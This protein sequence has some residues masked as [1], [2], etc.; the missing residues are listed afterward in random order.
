M[1]YDPS[2]IKGFPRT[3]RCIISPTIIDQHAYV[4]LKTEKRTIFDGKRFDDFPI[5]APDVDPPHLHPR[6]AYTGLLI[7]KE[8]DKALVGHATKAAPYGR[9]VCNLYIALLV[10]VP[11]RE[12]GGLAAGVDAWLGA[13]APAG[14]SYGTTPHHDDLSHG[15]TKSLDWRWS[16]N[17]C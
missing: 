7:L 9:V 8:L 6:F 1:S 15:S 10:Y 16:V 2:T 14:H 11:V 13:D 5:H 4:R 12:E 3:L 17:V